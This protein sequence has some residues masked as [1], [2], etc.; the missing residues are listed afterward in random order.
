MGLLLHNTLTRVKENF[1]PIDANNVKMYVCGPTVYDRS[2]I[3]NMR[4]AVFYDILYRLLQFLY[5]DVVYVRN[6]TDI[7]DKIIEASVNTG[8]PIPKLTAQMIQCYNDDTIAVGC[9]SP[10]FTPRATH[11]LNEIF[12]IISKLIAS[13]HAYIAEG[14]VLFHVKSYDLYGK[15]SG[16]SIDEMIAGARVE[17]APFKKHPAD[18]VLWKPAP[19]SEYKYGFDSPWGR[20][21]PGWHIECSA[22]SSYYLG[23]DFD[24]HGGGVDLVFPHHENE[25]AQSICANPGSKFARYWIHNG[26]LTVNGEKMSKSLNN[27]I[28]LRDLLDRG[29]SGV[30]IRYFYMMSHYRKPM[31]FNDNAIHSADKAIQKLG[32]VIVLLVELYDN[33]IQKCEQ[34]IS[35]MLKNKNKITKAIDILCDDVNTPKLLAYLQSSANDI[36]AQQT[37]N[38]DRKTFNEMLHQFA[39]T[40]MLIGFSPTALYQ[41]TT[42]DNDITIENEILIMANAREKAKT[43][44]DWQKADAI[45][46]QIT[47]KGYQIRDE[48]DGA[49]KILKL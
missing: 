28:I 18:F 10:T 33:D 15:L 44:K 42:K 3:G 4:S 37:Q 11:H 43:L 9:L 40:C 26:F 23:D 22:M 27:F 38:I 16:R 25:I 13:Q 20:G 32:V 6:I 34:S 29:I 39:M 7:D 49:F 14:H 8:I 30:I 21:R 2:H 5:P 12:E 17:V 31:D 36:I 24:I 41:Y 35:E 45:R 1:I 48:K 47:A 19:D 46:S